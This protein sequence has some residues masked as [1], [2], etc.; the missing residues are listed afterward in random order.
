MTALSITV[1]SDVITL[2][3]SFQTFTF[4][5][6]TN[7]SSVTVSFD[8]SDGY[9]SVDNIVWHDGTSVPEPGTIALIGM[10]FAGRDDVL[11]R[12]TDQ[13]GRLHRGADHLFAAGFCRSG[14]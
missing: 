2:D 7:V 12:V 13:Q 3:P 1:G 9:L 10:A 11:R 14:G 5:D 8:P 6:L 4:S